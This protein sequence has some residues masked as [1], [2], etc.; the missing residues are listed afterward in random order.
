[1]DVNIDGFVIGKGKPCFV[2]AEAGVNHNGKIDLAKK[3]VGVAKNADADAV[4]FQTFKTEKMLVKEAPKARYQKETTGE[5]TQYDLIKKL[6]LSEKDFKEL[7]GYA[8]RKGIMFLST[9]FDEESAN[10]LEELNVPAFKIGSGDLTNL[11]LLEYIAKKNKTMIVSTGMSTLDEVREAV[12]TVRN[13]G[14]NQI[15]LLHCT[16]NYPANIEDCNL[17]AMQTLEKEFDVPVGYSDHTIDITVP[18]AAVVMGACIIEKHFTLDKNLPGP[19]HRASLEPDELKE[20]IRQ[21]RLVEKAL[22][23]GE[24]KP[25]ESEM[26][27][28]KVARKSIVARVNIQ[29]GS[30]ITRGMLAIKR[31]GTGLV[32]KYYY[33]IVG[34]KAKK[35]I[36]ENKLMDWD[37]VE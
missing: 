8:K 19:D 30:I 16:S 14:N 20:M 23:T 25:A 18:V 15:I 2:I 26:E 24:K 4:K 17:R 37:M 11:Q 35:N 5:G 33:K 27:V 31:P 9:P 13:T 36:K 29:K 7:A 34:K 32:P 3:L 6:E 22:G 21:I 28:Q 1:M 10:L 12:E